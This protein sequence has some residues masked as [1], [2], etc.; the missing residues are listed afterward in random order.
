MDTRMHGFRF[1][2]VGRVTGVRLA[3][4][5]LL[6]TLT[7]PA[8]SFAASAAGCG[9]CDDDGD[10][11]TNADEYG[12]YGT[13]V[14]NAD[15]DGDGVADGYEVSVGYN[16]L[17]LDSDGDGLSDYDEINQADQAS[18]YD[19][20]SGDADGDGLTDGY[21]GQ[22]SLTDPYT[23]DTDGDG[24][25]DG[26]EIN[27]TGTDPFRADSDNDGKLDSCDRDPWVFDAGEGAPDGGLVGERLGCSSIS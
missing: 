22:V 1:G 19:Q 15:S 17:A 10:G 2:L 12:V 21:E 24:L 23:A 8:L 4:A 11:L 18:G 13:S 25:S 7:V 27:L 26:K 16:P 5:L 9:A 6:A 3:G 14:Q 20:G